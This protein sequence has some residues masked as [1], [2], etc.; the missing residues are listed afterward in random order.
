V[1]I[2]YDLSLYLSQ[3]AL[4]VDKL[5][6]GWTRVGA[7]TVTDIGVYVHGVFFVSDR[8]ITVHLISCGCAATNGAAI[9]ATE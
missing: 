4:Y 2:S 1:Y 6:P 5:A 9:I 8:I 3:L 7:Q